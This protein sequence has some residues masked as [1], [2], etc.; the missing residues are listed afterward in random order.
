MRILHISDT[1]SKHQFLTSLPEA[2]VIVHTGDITFEG[3][4]DKVFEF[5]KW[6]DSLHYK[7]K[8]FIAGN[9][10]F[11]LY[12]ND[13]GTLPKNMYYLRN[14]GV[15]IEGLNFYGIPM[16]FEDE[17]D[18][19]CDININNIPTDVDV[20]VSHQPPWGIYDGFKYHEQI[21]HIGSSHLLE[22]VLL[23]KPK[24]HLF[25]HNHNA[26]GVVTYNGTIFSNA[27]VLDDQYNYKN[28][29]FNLIQ[30]DA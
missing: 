19:T 16:F 24:V 17:M 15:V 20:L 10:D 8:V 4:F 14:S 6:F 5:V 12:N 30:I 7:Y 2:D 18:G 28:D 29:S 13:I 27:A 25:G 11:D 21:R 23:I 1:H 3:S 9:H 26:N 22:K